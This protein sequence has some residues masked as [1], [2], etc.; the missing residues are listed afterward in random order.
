MEV[1]HP[2]CAGLDVHKDTVMAAVRCVSAPR[3][4]EVRRF[5]TTTTGLLALAD[6]LTTHGCTHV[7]M[8]ATGVYWRLVVRGLARLDES[9]RQELLRKVVTRIVV[10]P[11]ALEVQGVLPIGSGLLRQR[12]SYRPEQ[13]E[14]RNSSHPCQFAWLCRQRPGWVVLP[15]L[16]ERGRVF[17]LSPKISVDSRPHSGGNSA[18]LAIPPSR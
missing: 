7:A 3:H 5:A 18:R 12:V 16:A 1:L 9:G 14:T 6:W 2:Q 11:D 4:Q 10:R 15:R 8:E 17:R 13:Q